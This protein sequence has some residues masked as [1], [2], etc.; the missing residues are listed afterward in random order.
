MADD[1][2]DGPRYASRGDGRYS[3][4]GRRRPASPRR[5]P[6]P[7][8]TDHV[9]A[10][11]LGWWVSP[12]LRLRV[13]GFPVHLSWSVVAFAIM[14]VGAWLLGRGSLVWAA[15][16]LGAAVASILV[17]EL[18]HAVAARRYG[19]GPVS[20]T[21]HGIGG[22]CVHRSTADNTERLVVALAGPAAGIALAG[23]AW[24]L[25]V[26]EVAGN[27]L[28]VEDILYALT[29]IGFVWSGLNL[30]PILPLDGGNALSALLRS[31]LPGLAMPVVWGVGLGTA[32]ACTAVAVSLGWWLGG[33]LAAYFAYENGR[34][35]WRW[36]NADRPRR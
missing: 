11:S 14:P 3:R 32:V 10:R 6:A 21:V 20:I 23:A 27:A 17:H 30:L 18:G 19:L 31:H 22:Y 29:W 35:L 8:T 33:L 15:V 36:R 7:A 5:P 13:V 25:S 9:R 26:S 4:T 28:V 12:G 34:N 2:D 24:G 1:H 16:W